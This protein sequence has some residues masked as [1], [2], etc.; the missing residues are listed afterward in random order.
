[1]L[2]LE[3]EAKFSPLSIKQLLISVQGEAGPSLQITFH[4]AVLI[5]LQM[6]NITNNINTVFPSLSFIKSLLDL[7]LIS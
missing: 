3:N 4:L 2:S 5:A 7:E 6:L 1:M